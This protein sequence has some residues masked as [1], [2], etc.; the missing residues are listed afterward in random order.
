MT[1]QNIKGDFYMCLVNCNIVEVENKE[2]K[3]NSDI[4]YA[5]RV[6]IEYFVC[7]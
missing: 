2:V 3:R 7:K 5:E 4:T 6:K 1:K